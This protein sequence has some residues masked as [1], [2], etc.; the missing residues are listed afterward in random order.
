[1]ITRITWVENTLK[2]IPKGYRILDVGAGEQQFKKFCL[3]LDYVSQDFAKYNGKGNNKGL[4]TENWNN[5]NIDIISDIVKIPEPDKSFD[6]IMCTEVFEHLPEPILAIKEFSRLIKIGGYL[7][8]TAPFC[9]LTH[10][11]PYHF[12]TGYNRYFYETHLTKYGF[13]IL[14]ITPNGN[15]F[16]YIAQELRRI[17]SVL[18]KYANSK[19]KIYEKI[20]I[21]FILRM[22]N[23][24]SRKDKNSNELLNFGYHIFARKLVQ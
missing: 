11:S 13:K 19:P 8:I 15:Y 22:L 6:A 9:S 7:I 4:Q 2:R 23:R 16:E 3:H 18:K 12:Y 10:H 1:M 20:A 21:G 24:F 17:P 14:E 5:K